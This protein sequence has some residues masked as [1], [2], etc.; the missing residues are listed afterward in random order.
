MPVT[1]AR[2]SAR[3]VHGHRVPAVAGDRLRVRALVGAGADRD[4]RLI[5]RRA[6]RA[7][8]AVQAR[9]QRF[10]RQGRA[11][12]RPSRSSMRTRRRR[13]G[14]LERAR[15]LERLAG[16]VAKL[17]TRATPLTSRPALH[18]PRSPRR[19][20]S[21]ARPSAAPSR[22]RRR[23][24]RHGCGRR[25]Y[26]VA[27]AGGVVGHLG[28][29][30]KLLTRRGAV[31][32]QVE[33][34]LLRADVPAVRAGPVTVPRRSPA[35]ERPSR[36]ATVSPGAALAFCGVSTARRVVAGARPSALLVTVWRPGASVT[37]VPGAARPST[38]TWTSRPNV[39]TTT[40]PASRAARARRA[41]PSSP[42]R[43]HAASIV[44]CGVGT[45][46]CAQRRSPGCG[47]TSKCAK[48]RC[49]RVHAQH[50]G[51]QRPSDPPPSHGRG[52]RTR[53]GSACRRSWRAP[54]AC[55]AGPG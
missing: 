13:D 53:R 12:W 9:V 51:G 8:V 49:G 17:L 5:A 1:F 43:V 40:R 2:A 11:P 45:S 26:G 28:V 7:A 20:N 3:Q 15:A 4:R 44:P 18:P 31:R 32:G 35:P 38:R 42:E 39:G 19:R 55:C 22:W 33:R 41:S 34:R 16:A 46:P 21:P 10:R 23:G 36:N 37:V 14:R 24:R 6:G 54:T 29:D 47:A 27:A 48:P 52:S 50:V 25:P 30:P